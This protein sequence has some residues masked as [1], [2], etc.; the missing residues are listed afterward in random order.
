MFSKE[1]LDC[2]SVI[3]IA[4]LMPRK[5][6]LADSNSVVRDGFL[7]IT[8][9]ST[10]LK[11]YMNLGFEPTQAEKDSLHNF[12]ASWGGGEKSDVHNTIL[13]MEFPGF[14]IPFYERINSI[15]GC[16]VDPNV[17]HSK[18]DVYVSVEYHRSVAKEVND[19][20]IDF[21]TKDHIFSKNFIYSGPQ[22][23]GLPY[24]LELYAKNGNSLEQFLLVS[25]AWKYHPEEIRKQNE[26]VMQNLGKYVPKEFSDGGSQ[27][28]IFKTE[29]P[30]IK[31]NAKSEVVSQED[32]LV[33]FQI[34]SKFFMDF[35]NEVIKRY[36]GPIFL[37]LEITLEKQISYY[38]VENS[39]HIQ[40]L[41]GISENWKRPA[42]SD[43]INYV[44][45]LVSLNDALSNENP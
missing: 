33:E 19:I 4:N 26:G 13:E 1:V 40:F 35:S 8:R 32:N 45:S 6:N 5:L 38:I 25:T 20:I 37:Q 9:D 2:C 22:P 29:V 34:K 24:L 17:F 10:G 36:T 11:A 18:G 16:R 3:K 27:K 42:R 21:L 30:S 7:F 31:G 28:L 44:E 14:V 43:H 12:L 15:P 23:K 39:L 41:K